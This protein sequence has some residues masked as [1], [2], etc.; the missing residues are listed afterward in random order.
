MS[1]M[2]GHAVDHGCTDLD[3][4]CGEGFGF[5]VHWFFGVVVQDVVEDW[6]EGVFSPEGGAAL[7]G[8]GEFFICE[9][10]VF[11]L[12]YRGEV[13]FPGVIC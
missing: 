13:V 9:D 4:F 11:E 7:E 10:V 12:D 8:C 2:K 6:A 1:S 3:F 5:G